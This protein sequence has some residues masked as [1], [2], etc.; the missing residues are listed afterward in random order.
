MG[1]FETGPSRLSSSRPVITDLL[2]HPSANAGWLWKVHKAPSYLPN[3]KPKASWLFFFFCEFTWVQPTQRALQCPSAQQL[4]SD[5]QR[6]VPRWWRVFS[7]HRTNISGGH[8]KM[9]SMC[10]S[11]L[12]WLAVPTPKRAKDLGPTRTNRASLPWLCNEAEIGHVHHVCSV[13]SGKY[14]PQEP[15]TKGNWGWDKPNGCKIAH[16]VCVSFLRYCTAI[17]DV[18]W[19]DVFIHGTSFISC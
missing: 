14:S 13:H 9:K 3:V 10:S 12:Y 17:F 18:C 4:P 1:C 15:Q 8:T 11:P 16:P 2:L 7:A 5:Q 19:D 6:T